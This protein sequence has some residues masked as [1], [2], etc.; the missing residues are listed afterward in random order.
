VKRDALLVG[1]AEENDRLVFQLEKTHS[2]PFASLN[3]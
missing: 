3:R 2:T 1:N